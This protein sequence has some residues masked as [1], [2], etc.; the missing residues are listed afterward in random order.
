MVLWLKTGLERAKSHKTIQLSFSSGGRGGMKR[1]TRALKTWK[2]YGSRPIDQPFSTREEDSKTTSNVDRSFSNR[3]DPDED[4]V[5]EV[6]HDVS[7]VTN[8]VFKVTYDF[9]KSNCK[10]QP[11]MPCH[12]RTRLVMMKLS[13]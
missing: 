1:R 12:L 3:E 13:R 8:D 7:E 4:L 2:N 6:T 9:P 11:L 5:P 10:I